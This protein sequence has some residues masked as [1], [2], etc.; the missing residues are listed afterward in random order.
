L[1][2]F[3][4]GSANVGNTPIYEWQKS[5]GEKK[6]LVRIEF[7]G[8]EPLGVDD[9]RVL[10]GLVAMAG[11]GGL[12]LSNAPKTREEYALRDLI[13]L[14]GVSCHDQDLIAI[15]GSYRELAHE[16][17]YKNKRYTAV[18]RSCIERLWKVNII[19]QVEGKRVGFRLLSTYASNNNTGGVYV[20][21]NPRL[22]QAILGDMPHTRINM[23]E[24]RSLKTDP[25]RLLY[26][27]L[28][29]W[30]DPGKTGRAGIDILCSYI[31]LEK[32][33]PIAIRKRR[34][35]ARAVL[36]DE[37]NT[38]EGWTVKEYAKGK[39]SISRPSYKLA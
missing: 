36:I 7:G 14:Q 20:A 5:G 4:P 24:V 2:Y 37:I 33:T 39:F 3:A 10:Q 21:L 17:G 25:A 26:Q 9:L 22:A 32:A 18:I 27:R 19:V 6:D 34:Q 11:P 13:E 28:C 31:W 16:I 15:K 29:A 8:E 30:I 1:I 23:V 35:R 38:L 12:V